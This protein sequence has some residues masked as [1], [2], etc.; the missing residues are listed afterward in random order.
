MK[1]IILAAGEGKRLRPLTE[2][3]P[4]AMVS[5]WGKSLLERQLEQL[6][7]MGIEDVQIV[8]GYQHQAIEKLKE[9]WSI[10]TV[11]NPDYSRTN[12]VF[13][14]AQA[15]EFVGKDEQPVLILYGDIAYA[16]Q[17]LQALIESQSTSPVTVLGNSDWFELWS[18]RLDDPLSDAETFLYSQDMQLTEI[19]NKPH[20]IEQVQAQYMGMIK[21]DA[22]YLHQLL[23]NYLNH[24]TNEK[25]RNWY[26]TDLIQTVIKDAGVHVELVKGSWI[27][28]DTYEDYQLYAEKVPAEFGLDY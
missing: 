20:S 6:K 3:Q 15:L 19:G 23:D 13:S 18:Q 10:S 28:I 5:I 16:D 25:V 27:E 17:H 11:I 9:K 12:M 7:K 26:L 24:A 8:C 14:L 22:T 4:K 21:T 2:H 1:A